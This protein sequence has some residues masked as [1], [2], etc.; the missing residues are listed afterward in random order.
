MRELVL[1][2]NAVEDLRALSSLAELRRLD[3]CRNAAGD[4]RPLAARSSL[5]WVQVGRGRGITDLG[6]LDVP[7]VDG[8]AAADPV[9]VVLPLH[10]RNRVG[11]PGAAVN[12]AAPQ[13]RLCSDDALHCLRDAGAAGSLGGP[14][15]GAG[16][17]PADALFGSGDLRCRDP[18]QGG[19][20]RHR[21]HPATVQERR[22]GPYRT[23]SCR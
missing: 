10:G 6:P 23:Q 14:A 4:L 7:A 21:T 9:E 12:S 15:E 17:D 5:A 8:A 18:A 19:G 20:L 22:F 1:A 11:D 3:L 13:E 2:D 16:A